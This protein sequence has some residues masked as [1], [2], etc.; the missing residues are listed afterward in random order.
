MKQIHTYRLLDIRPEPGGGNQIPGGV[1]ERIDYTPYG[2][3]RHRSSVDNKTSADEDYPDGV[4][5]LK[6]SGFF[7]SGFGNEEADTD[8]APPFGV[9]DGADATRFS[10][11]FGRG[12]TAP[13]GWLSDP[14]LALTVGT[15]N[16]IGFSGYM[17]DFEGEHYSQRYRVYIPELGRW[18]QRDPIGYVDGMNLYE[19][20]LS[21]PNRDTDPLGLYPRGIP[22]GAIDPGPPAHPPGAWMPFLPNGNRTNKPPYITNPNISQCSVDL[23]CNRVTPAIHTQYGS[24]P[25]TAHCY[26][27]I[28]H[29]DGS[30]TEV[31]A[32]PLRNGNS[33][34]SS[35]NPVS[36]D[37]CGCD[38]GTREGWGPIVPYI[39]PH[40]PG[41]R[42]DGKDSPDG[43]DSPDGGRPARVNIQLTPPT[44]V[45]A[46]ELANCLMRQ[47]QATGV[48]CTQYSVLG[49][50]SNTTISS[51]LSEC[52]LSDIKSPIFAPGWGHPGLP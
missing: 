50:N 11:E 49:P 5:D 17:F 40:G 12:N 10:A 28:T 1:V 31:R 36:D 43:T 7:S 22:P 14:A 24:I 23:R 39:G 13:A 44:G 52:G 15:D 29:P 6:D 32:G 38:D 21:S 26:L 3:A 41:A 48:S 34:G 51:A 45:T 18:G 8:L 25:E 46:C 35:N 19:Y 20:V 30:Q 9:W 16:S 2:V 4:L 42:P 27:V 37:P 47:V 33:S